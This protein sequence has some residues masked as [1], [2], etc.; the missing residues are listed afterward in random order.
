M[1]PQMTGRQRYKA[2]ALI[3]RLCANYDGEPCVRVQSI[4]YCLL[5]KYFRKAVLPAEPKLEAEILMSGAKT[6]C[7]R[8]GVPIEKHSNRQ[9]YCPECARIMYLKNKA[10]YQRNKRSGVDN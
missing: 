7:E 2:N 6:V 9:K 4:S 10:K 3:K 5:C 1:L 8:C